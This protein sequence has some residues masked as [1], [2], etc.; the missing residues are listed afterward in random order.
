MKTYTVKIN[1]NGNILW[2]KENTEILHRE[3]GPAIEYNNGDKAWYKEGLYH[4][5]DGP[6]LEY[7]DGRKYWHID[8]IE[9]TEE[10]FK[11]LVYSNKRLNKTTCEGRVIEID[12]KKYKLVDITSK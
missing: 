3:D 2:Y 11:M 1:D 10:K 6:A 9:L 7:A 8:G 12:G 5:E 4:R